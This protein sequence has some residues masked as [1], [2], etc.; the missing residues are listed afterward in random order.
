MMNN[1]GVRIERMSL[2]LKSLLWILSSNTFLCLK[3]YYQNITTDKNSWSAESNKNAYL[4]NVNV[5]GLVA[6]PV[7]IRVFYQRSEAKHKTTS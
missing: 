3:N 6:C 7:T 1:E 4:W 5:D 2:I